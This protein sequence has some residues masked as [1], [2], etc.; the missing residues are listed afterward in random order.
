MMAGLFAAG[1]LDMLTLAWL[2]LAAFVAGIIDAIG[3]GGGLVTVPALALAGLGPVA[4]VATNKINASFGTGSSTLAFARAGRI[5]LRRMGPPALAAG[6]GGVAGAL[7][8]PYAPNALIASALPVLLVAVALYFAF[9]PGFGDLDHPARLRSATL[10]A[11]VIPAIGFY[12][13]VF[14][15]GAG[16]FYMAAFAALAGLSAIGAAA[17]TRLTNF[18]SNFGSAVIYILAGQVAWTAALAMAP[19]QFLGSQLGARLA[20]K[21]GARLIRPVLIVVSIALAARLASLPGHPLG[22]WV[23]AQTRDILAH[24]F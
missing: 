9:S 1:S 17:H 14:G 8:L 24:F 19:C 6:A 4:A 2:A 22:D 16:S 23:R 20:M 15:P 21:G 12:D 5:D 10:T 18:A 7:A 11:F 13:G 3:G